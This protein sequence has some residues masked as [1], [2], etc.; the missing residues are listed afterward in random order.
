MYLIIC[1]MIIYSIIISYIILYYTIIYYISMFIYI[2]ISYRE[3]HQFQHS[4]FSAFQKWQIWAGA[5]NLPTSMV[6][7][8][9]ATAGQGKPH[10]SRCWS[11]GGR[12]VVT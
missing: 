7:T 10:A 8:A 5:N 11:Q 6:V 9:A 3:A 4:N 12:K 1:Y 2:Y